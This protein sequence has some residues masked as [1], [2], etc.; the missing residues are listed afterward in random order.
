MFKKF[1]KF[2]QLLLTIIKLD[3]DYNTQDDKKD[4]TN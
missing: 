4:D 1:K 2:I 3:P